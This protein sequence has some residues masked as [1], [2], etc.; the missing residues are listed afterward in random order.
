MKKAL[1]LVREAH[2]AGRSKNLPMVSRL[3]HTVLD[4]PIIF[5]IRGR[6]GGQLRHEFLGGASLPKETSDF[7]DDLGIPF[8]EGCGLTETSSIIA[9]IALGNRTAGTAGGG[10]HGRHDG[11]GWGGGKDLLLRSEREKDTREIMSLVP[12]GKTL[13]FHTGDLGRMNADGYLSITGR[14]KE[15]YKLEFSHVFLSFCEIKYLS[16]CIPCSRARQYEI[17]SSKFLDWAAVA[18]KLSL[19]T[20]TSQDDT[21]ETYVEGINRYRIIPS[22]RGR[23]HEKFETPRRLG[24]R[25]TA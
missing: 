12:D 10:G 1:S 20:E 16:K 15:Q 8:Y 4:S 2:N 24:H 3:A 6:F 7:M 11:E 18:T 14:L 25:R 19:N 21:P 22:V 17:G 9:I 23:Q 13:L 5:K